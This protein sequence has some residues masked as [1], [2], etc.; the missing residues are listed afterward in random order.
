MRAFKIFGQNKKVEGF[1]RKK[2]FVDCTKTKQ[3]NK[4]KN[5][6]KCLAEIFPKSTLKVKSTFGIEKIFAFSVEVFM[7]LKAKVKKYALP[8]NIDVN[9]LYIMLIFASAL[10]FSLPL[11]L[12]LSRTL[13]DPVI[14]L[15]LWNC[16]T[17]GGGNLDKV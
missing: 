7:K 2:M 5:L 15:C 10:L 14:S 9:E 16:L 6:N 1:V 3:I 17:P 8:T 11:L 4:D 13:S 12:F